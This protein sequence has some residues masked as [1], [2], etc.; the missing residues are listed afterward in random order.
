MQQSPKQS[1]ENKKN[2]ISHLNLS[3]DL[4]MNS[5]LANAIQSLS[6]SNTNRGNEEDS[7]NFD[8]FGLSMEEINVLYSP[9][10]EF[11]PAEFNLHLHSNEGTYQH[12]GFINRKRKMFCVLLMFFFFRK[13]VCTSTNCV[14]IAFT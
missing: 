11:T 13:F 5:S 8:S 1:T 2:S 7:T 12:A 4:Q 14:L 3:S 10:C 9:T 6:S